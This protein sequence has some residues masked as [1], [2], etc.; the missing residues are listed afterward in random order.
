[1]LNVSQVTV[2]NIEL[3]LGKG[4]QLVRAAG[5]VAKLIAKDGKLATLSLPSGEIRLIS[6]N[7]STTVG[8]V[9]NVEENQKSLGRTG[10]LHWLGKR[11]VV[12]GVVMNPI[13]HH[14]WRW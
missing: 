3:T 1:M 7:C 13:D 6:K 2:H 9:G 10:S 12:R 8:Q 14:P 11:H 5:A 4:E